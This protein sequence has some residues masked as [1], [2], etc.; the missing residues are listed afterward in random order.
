MSQLQTSPNLSHESD[1]RECCNSIPSD[2]CIDSELQSNQSLNLA[3]IEF[4]PSQFNLGLD[5]L[6]SCLITKIVR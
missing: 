3:P 2:L 1:G 4:H 5:M 6:Q